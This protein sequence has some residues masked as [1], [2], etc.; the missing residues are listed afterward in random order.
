MVSTRKHPTISF[1]V[2]HI[3]PI[4]GILLTLCFEGCTPILIERISDYI[5]ANSLLISSIPS[6][7][8]YPSV[9]PSQETLTSWIANYEF[10]TR[11]NPGTRYLLYFHGK[12]L[13]DQGLPAVS[14]E[15]GVYEY[16][17]ILKKFESY[18][19][20]VISER[21]PK[22]ADVNLY[23]RATAKQIK[24]LLEANVPPQNITVVGASKGA[25]IA[26]TVTSLLKNDRL[27]FVLLGACSSEMIDYW[28]QNGMY[29]YGNILAIYDSVDVYASSC[30][31]LFTFSEGKG[32]ARREEIVLHTG[33]GHGILYQPLDEWMAPIAQFAGIDLA[34]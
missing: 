12:I 18:G 14:P 24:L 10:P 26:A 7:T 33:L 29:L 15:Y 28:K 17:A 9:T 34:P 32:I 27:N 21:R 19:F 4:I 16:E 6:K 5:P 8:P 31:E 3:Q 22:N 1:K 13:E 20:T 23:A 25:Y 11:I 2:L 30:K